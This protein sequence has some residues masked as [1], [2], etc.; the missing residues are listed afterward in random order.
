MMSAR[1]GPASPRTG[2]P[3]QRSHMLNNRS[4]LLGMLGVKLPPESIAR[5]CSGGECMHYLSR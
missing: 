3:Q 2:K 4:E 1:R 5:L